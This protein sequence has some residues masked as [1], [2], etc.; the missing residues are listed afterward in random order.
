RFRWTY[1]KRAASAK[2][3]A[4]RRCVCSVQYSHYRRPAPFNIS[5]RIYEAHAR[6]C[7]P[8]LRCE[9]SKCTRE[10]SVPQIRARQQR[11]RLLPIELKT[12]WCY[13][14]QTSTGSHTSSFKVS[15]HL[16]LHVFY[17]RC[18]GISRFDMPPYS[19]M[20]HS[21]CENSSRRNQR[22]HRKSA[23]KMPT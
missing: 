19:H 1:P 3:V 22:K 8:A 5:N 7:Q 11:V 18:V 6:G 14:E 4:G 20:G 23:Q 2:R 17:R 21:V 16:L 10:N 12:K 9:Q 13:N 15:R